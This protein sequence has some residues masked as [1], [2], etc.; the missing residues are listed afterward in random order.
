MDEENHPEPPEDLWTDWNSETQGVLGREYEDAGH[1]GRHYSAVRMTLG[2]FFLGGA[3]G[4]ISLRWDKPDTT[5]AGWA[6]AIAILGVV[7]FVWFSTLTFVEMN[8]QLA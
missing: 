7:L 8:K 6:A 1:W 5:T 4:L 3:V 2:T